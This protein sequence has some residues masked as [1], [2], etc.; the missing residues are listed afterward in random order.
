MNTIV[1]R[2]TNLTIVLTLDCNFN[3]NY[4]KSSYKKD[5]ENTDINIFFKAVDSFVLQS[6]KDVPLRIAFYGGEPSLK[7]DNIKKIKDYAEKTYSYRNWSFSITTNLS[8][9]NEDLLNLYKEKNFDIL[10]SLDGEKKHNKNRIFRNSNEETFDIVIKNINILK[11]NNIFPRIRVTFSNEYIDDFYNIIEFIDNTVEQWS[12][13]WIDRQSWDNISYDIFKDQMIKV[14]DYAE[15]KKD[16]KIFK[17]IYFFSMVYESWANIYLENP[18]NND[19]LSCGQ[20]SHNLSIDY[21]GNYFPCHHFPSYYQKNKDDRIL[22]G[23]IKNGFNYDKINNLFNLKGKEINNCLGIECPVSHSNVCSF[24]CFEDSMDY[25][26]GE[27][28]CMYF[29][30]L[31][32]YEMCRNFIEDI[33]YTF[34]FDKYRAFYKFIDIDINFIYN[35]EMNILR[36]KLIKV[37]ALLNIEEIY[38]NNLFLEINKV[39]NRLSLNNIENN[40]LKDATKKMDEIF[41][42]LNISEKRN[43]RNIPIEILKNINKEII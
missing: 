13:N 25:N 42:Y 29:F 39:A 24:G 33:F 18:Y 1:E 14:L 4:C 38:T 16:S 35:K 12:L 9:I 43:Y 40:S 11:K 3:C 7:F 28:K 19:V 23:D 32:L 30:R 17:K 20:C 10:V 41:K 22:I 5:E 26:K 8:F 6:K 37:K 27:F 34:D 21:N 2:Y 31:H 36:N 15:K